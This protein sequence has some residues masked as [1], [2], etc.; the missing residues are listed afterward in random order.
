MSRVQ[1]IVDRSDEVPESQFPSVAIDF[2]E[3]QHISVYV[4][5]F[6]TFL[7]AVGFHPDNVKEHLGEEE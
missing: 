7:L 3:G 5:N 2:D 6:R 1:F 4:E